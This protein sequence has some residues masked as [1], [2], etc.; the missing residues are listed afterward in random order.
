MIVNGVKC[1]VCHHHLSPAILRDLRSIGADGNSML[2]PGI[3]TVADIRTRA[4]S[5]VWRVNGYYANP[6]RRNV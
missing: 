5:N 1:S 3:V 4:E 6:N 2:L